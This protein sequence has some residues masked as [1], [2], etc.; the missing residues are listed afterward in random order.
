LVWAKLLI[1]QLNLIKL[2]SSE[3]PSPNFAIA[4]IDAGKTNVIS[5][6][7]DALQWIGK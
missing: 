2:V 6:N 5:R 7:I 3:S 1:D 4:K